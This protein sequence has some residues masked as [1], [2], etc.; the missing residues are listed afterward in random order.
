M[1]DTTKILVRDF[2][3]PASIGIYAHEQHITQRIRVNV[4]VTLANA[5]I[6]RDDIEDTMSYEGLA[7]A[8]LNLAQQ[9]FNLVETLAEHL[10]QFALKDP[11]AHSAWVRVEKLDIYPEGVVGAEV[12]RSRA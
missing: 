3:V 6:Q 8:I 1:T 7:E 10:A 11:R 12:F 4:E 9:H 2:I 5:K